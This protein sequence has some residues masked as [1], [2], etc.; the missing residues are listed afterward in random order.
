MRCFV[1]AVLAAT[2]LIGI[3]IVGLGAQPAASAPLRAVIVRAQPGAVEQAETEVMRVGGAVGR[4]LPIVDGFAARLPASADM[5]PGVAS[6]TPDASLRL[7]GSSYDAHQDADSL[8][9]LENMVGARTMWNKWTGTGVDVALLDSGVA[10]VAGLDGA[11][12]VLS[13]PDL[14]EESQNPQLAHLDTFG[15]GTFLAGIIAGHDPGIDPAT[16][17]GNATAFLGMAPNARIVSVK[18]ADAHGSTDVSQVLAGIDWVVE[19]A[20]DPGINI[21][22]LNLSFGTDSAQNYLTDPLTYAAEV[23]WRNGIVVVTSAGN[24]GTAAGQLTDPAFDPSIIAVGA[25]DM[26]GSPSTTDDTIAAFSSRG[27]GTRNPDLVAPGVHVQ[28]LRVPGSYV[29]AQY[30]A[31]GTITSRYFRGSGTSQAAAVVSG[32]AALLIQEHPGYTPDQIKQLLVGTALKLPSASATAQGAGLLNLRAAS[33]PVT[34]RPTASAPAAV[35]GGS[36]D[37]ARGSA[38]LQLR[39]TL[40]DG[41][42][43]I[44]GQPVDTA[45]LAAS[46]AA[47][48]SW[49]GGTWSGSTWSGSTWSGSTWSGSTWS[50]ADWTGSTWSSDNWS[51]GTWSGSTWSG[52]TWSGSTWSGSTWSGSTWSGSTWSGSTWSGS[53]WSQAVWATDS[54]S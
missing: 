14:T 47:G 13:G 12:Q 35:G 26:N 19:H 24:A 21:R 28:S 10:P 2:V 22:V 32:A 17:T 38:Y 44:F 51:S 1:R 37:A 43:D 18:V 11:D 48:T 34:L 23:A 16:N 25:D 46:E 20:H 6:I 31:T 36:L 33:G 42:R 4:P 52:S 15:H 9:N 3:P 40:L 45:A 50:G 8:F 41:D 30:G 53:T 5:L 54:W 39:G 49:S 29:D 7:A 27:N